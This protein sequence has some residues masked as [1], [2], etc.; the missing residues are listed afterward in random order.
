MMTSRAFPTCL[1]L[2]ACLVAATLPVLAQSGAECSDATTQ[3]SQGFADLY[4]A[5]GDAVMGQPLDCEHPAT[6]GSGDVWQDTTTGLAY[7]RKATNVPGFTDGYH[8]W[9]LVTNQVVHMGWRCC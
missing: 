1:L 6:D 4:S 3:F 9:A 5:L 7:W 2:L 8:H